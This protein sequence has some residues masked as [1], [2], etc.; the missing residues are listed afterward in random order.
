[1]RKDKSHRTNIS[2][3]LNIL[4][5]YILTHIPKANYK[6]SMSKEW[7][8]QMKACTHART[9]TGTHL[10]EDKSQNK[11]SSDIQTI[12]Q[13]KQV[14]LRQLLC[15]KKNI[16]YV[17]IFSTINILMRRNDYNVICKD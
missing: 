17:L 5:I 11:A 3:Q 8:E 4:F 6:T 1:L 15:G 16:I 14:Q 13:I 10:T 2:I 7:K 12:T 9:Y